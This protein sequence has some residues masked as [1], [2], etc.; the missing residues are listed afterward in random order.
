METNG[1]LTKK[2][3]ITNDARAPFFAG[4]KID[5]YLIY[6]NKTDKYNFAAMEKFALEKQVDIL[7]IKVPRKRSA[8]LNQISYYKQIKKFT[9]KDRNVYIYCSPALCKNTSL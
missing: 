7:F 1:I 2:K 5:E 9:G 4:I 8:S 3:I 6:K